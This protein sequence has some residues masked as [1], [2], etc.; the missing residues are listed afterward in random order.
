MLAAFVP[1]YGPAI[2]SRNIRRLS[3][4][5]EAT[6][7]ETAGILENITVE[8]KAVRLVSLQNRMVLDM[9][10]A[11]RGGRM[12]TP[13]PVPPI[14]VSNALIMREV[15]TQQLMDIDISDNVPQPHIV[16]PDPANERTNVL[17]TTMLPI[18]EPIP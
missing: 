14:T 17:Y 18:Y 1:W 2:N 12:I 8:L 7:D 6:I 13:P 11:E 4:L 3:R 10:L 9:M 5:L 16:S 15:V